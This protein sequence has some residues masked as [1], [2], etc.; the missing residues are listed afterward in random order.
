VLRVVE[1]GARRPTLDDSSLA[2]HDDLLG[3]LPHDR[4][5]VA[6]QQVADAG[7]VPDVGEQVEHLR[8]DRHVERGDRLVEDQHLRLGGERPRDRHPLPLTA[9]QR[10]GWHGPLPAVEPDE[11]GKL[12]DPLPAPL[13]VPAVVDAQ[14]LV[15]RGFRAV[16]WIEAGVRVLEDD[17]HLTAALP[18]PARR[19]GGHAAVVA[20]GAYPAAGWAL[21]PDDHPGDR[22]LAGA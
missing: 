9:G 1:H 4:E 11:P 6:D 21:K 16:P 14:H 15:D 22:G 5:V 17:L 7:R 13:R 10:P 18:A 20:A 2:H 19:A 8:L 3:E 12:G